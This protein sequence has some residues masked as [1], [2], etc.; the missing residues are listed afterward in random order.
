MY[1]IKYFFIYCSLLFVPMLAQSVY[2][3]KYSNEFLNIGVN[4]RNIAMG[5][6]SVAFTGDVT[7]AYWNPAGL[8]KIAHKQ[9]IAAM[10]NEYF[11]GMAQYNYIG[12]SIPIDSSS[13]FAISYIRLSIDDIPDTRYLFDNSGNNNSNVYGPID[14]N[15]IKYF[16]AAD[17]A[18]LISFAK[19]NKKFGAAKY[20]GMYKYG[21]RTFLN[22]SSGNNLSFGGNFKIIHRKIGQFADAWGFGLDVG[23]QMVY[24]KWQFGAF[25]K[26]ASNTF[27]FWNINSDMFKTAYSTY[28]TLDSTS[29]NSLPSKT[30]E[31][32]L[33]KLIVGL[34]RSLYMNK[35][36]SIQLRPSLDVDFT[37]DGKRNV[38]IKSKTISGDV[39][40]GLELCYK[41]KLFI[42]T[43]INN[44]QELKDYN[45]SKY[46]TLQP[47][48][49]VGVQFTRFALDYA[50]INPANASVGLYSHVFS[51]RLGLNDV[52]K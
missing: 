1:L 11:G 33:P 13:R 5:N 6:T 17:N 27:N 43:G 18:F 41:K 31:I 37:F 48:A 4:A 26:D 10:H 16:S 25:L 42:R 32:T 47:N 44:F 9:E 29:Q 34:S 19:Q 35:T 52:K 23:A 8:T 15:K 49:G 50:I 3:S 21:V 2:T 40:V 20:L 14:Y 38:L 12:A 28:N 51:V 24:N 30:L 45:G 22:D 36:K 7:S 39:K 46:Y